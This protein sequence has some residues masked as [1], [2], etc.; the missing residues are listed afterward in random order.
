MINAKLEISLSTEVSPYFSS[1][2]AY[3]KA[4]FIKGLALFPLDVNHYKIPMFILNRPATFAGHSSKFV[5][6]STINCIAKNGKK[7]SSSL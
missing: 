4:F 7:K 1:M 5:A 3:T 2:H 6:A